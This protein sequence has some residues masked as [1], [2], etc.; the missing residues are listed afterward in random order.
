MT[1]ATA[2]HA[3]ETYKTIG[4]LDRTHL[5]IREVS[6]GG[7]K[8]H[9][10]SADDILKAVVLVGPD[11]TDNTVRIGRM[12]GY[13]RQADTCNPAAVVYRLL[14]RKRFDALLLNA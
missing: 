4:R 10:M 6:N 12:D 9:V 11:D 14:T 2:T 5:K 8:L 3:A 13:C 1:H 7:V